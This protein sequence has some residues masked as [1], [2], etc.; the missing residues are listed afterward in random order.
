MLWQT[1]GL[2]VAAVAMCVMTIFGMILR[3]DV[4]DAQDRIRKLEQ[5]PE[6]NPFEDFKK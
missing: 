4:E 5:R 3:H 2:F 1:I 6:E